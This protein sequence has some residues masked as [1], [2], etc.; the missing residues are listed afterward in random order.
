VAPLTTTN[1]NLLGVPS[2]R[3]AA[4][5]RI[6]AVVF[7][8]SDRRSWKAIGSGDTVA[9]AITDARHGCPDGTTW[10]PLSWNDL[11]GE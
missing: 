10:S 11:Y 7:H 4:E 9:A 1:A 5:Q 8:S 2:A 6:L 3:A